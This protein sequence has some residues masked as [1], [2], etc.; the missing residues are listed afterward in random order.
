MKLEVA[1]T[2]GADDDHPGVA[3]QRLVQLRGR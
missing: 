3:G 1:V 2:V